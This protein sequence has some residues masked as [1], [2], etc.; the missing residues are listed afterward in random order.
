MSP[1]IK[2][3]TKVNIVFLPYQK[4]SKSYSFHIN[5]NLTK[6]EKIKQIT[7]FLKEVL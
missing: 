3:T 7:N 6:E 5:E 2:T 1:P 4:S